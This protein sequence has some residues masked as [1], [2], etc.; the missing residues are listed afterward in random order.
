M[1]ILVVEDE[2]LL[3][4]QI[5]RGLR[6]NRHV[7]DLVADGPSAVAHATTH[8]YDLLVLDVMLPGI[9]GYAVCREVRAAGIRT[10]ILMLTARREVRDRVEGLDAGA[11]DYLTKPFAFAE[12]LA[13]IRA[14]ERREPGLRLGPL[15]AGDL[16]LDP[17]THKVERAGQPIH[18][19]PREHAILEYLLRHRGQVLSRDQIAASAWELGAEHASN[20][21]DV[22]IRNLRRKIDDPHKI[23][24]LHTVRGAGYAIREP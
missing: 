13:R 20:V 5:A 2:R 8:A 22:F 11:D 17:V 3:A 18:L 16:I 9:D 23:K 1:H 19:T 6:E 12:L 4:D 10:P 24:L 14:L 21:V 15:Q 7:V